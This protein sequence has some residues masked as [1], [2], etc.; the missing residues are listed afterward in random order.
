MNK[1]DIR[2]LFEKLKND[3]NYNNDDIKLIAELINHYSKTTNTIDNA[4]IKDF[5]TIIKS[6]MNANIDKSL[7]RYKNN[8]YLLNRKEPN[9]YL[10][11]YMKEELKNLK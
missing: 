8:V 6:L 3:N 7:N 5:T 11:L 10:Q 4:D 9:I 1:E 2:N